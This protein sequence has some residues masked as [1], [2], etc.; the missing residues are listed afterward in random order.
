MLK[1]LPSPGTSVQGPLFPLL[2]HGQ[3]IEYE[4]HVSIFPSEQVEIV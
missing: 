3:R 2:F 1:Q 4:M